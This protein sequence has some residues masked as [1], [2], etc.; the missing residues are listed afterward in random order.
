[1][2]IAAVKINLMTSPVKC[3]R[4]LSSQTESGNRR[5]INRNG[6]NEGDERSSKRLKREWRRTDDLSWSKQQSQQEMPINCCPWWRDDSGARMMMYPFQ[7]HAHAIIKT[8]DFAALAALAFREFGLCVSARRTIMSLRSATINRYV[9]R[10]RALAII[11]VNNS[12]VLWLSTVHCD[13]VFV[14]WRLSVVSS[15]VWQRLLDD[16][17]A[18]NANYRRRLSCG[19]DFSLRIER[20]DGMLNIARANRRHNHLMNN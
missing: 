12:R 9:N 8:V 11:C 10:R 18:C 6:N 14:N 15:I 5:I 13:C 7:S 1:M 19:R 16:L 2:S 3:S 20:L 4:F 17:T